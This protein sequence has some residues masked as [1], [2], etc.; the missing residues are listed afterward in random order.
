VRADYEYQGRNHWT[1]PRQD[2]NSAQYDPANY[3]LSATKFASIRAGMQFDAWSVEPFIDNLFDTHTVTNYDFSIDYG[4]GGD[5]LQR[6]WTYR[7]RTYGV[8]A[9]YRY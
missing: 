1:S 4:A 2:V 9:T 3:T 6:Q 8:T 7:P 5:R